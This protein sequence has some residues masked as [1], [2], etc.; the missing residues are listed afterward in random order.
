MARK[1]RTSET[2]NILA[3][4][5]IA[6]DLLAVFFADF[7]AAFFAVDFDA[8]FLVRFCAGPLARRSARS[9]GSCCWTSR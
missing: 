2:N 1:K 3:K 6:P 8:A 4:T 9:F 7:L 5:S